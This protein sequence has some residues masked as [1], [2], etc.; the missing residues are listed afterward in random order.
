[1]VAPCYIL[2]DLKTRKGRSAAVNVIYGK[3]AT[4][5][6]SAGRFG[7]LR[8]RHNGASAPSSLISPRS[9]AAMPASARISL[10][11]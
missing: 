10:A 8:V 2:V 1:M 7:A 9:D 4:V 5:G 6:P 3:S 11:C